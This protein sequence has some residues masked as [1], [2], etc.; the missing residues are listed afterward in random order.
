MNKS[1]NL[2]IILVFTVFSNFCFA[3]SIY[4]SEFDQKFSCTNDNNQNIDLIL[5]QQGQK[6]LIYLASTKNKTFFK[7]KTQH[8]DNIAEA[9]V[10][11]SNNSSFLELA[12]TDHIAFNTT[13]TSTIR[14]YY[15]NDTKTL[16]FDFNNISYPT[17]LENTTPSY[18]FNEGDCKQAPSSN[19][20]NNIST[21]ITL[22]KIFDTLKVYYVDKAEQQKCFDEIK[23]LENR[24]QYFYGCTMRNN[25]D[26]ENLT[27]D[28]KHE[29][30][31][32][33]TNEAYPSFIGRSIN[34]VKSPRSC[35]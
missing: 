8:N 4:L 28:T 13:D 11:S 35:N 5:Y 24:K 7:F 26:D 1:T 23:Q 31:L 18:Q 9:M 27:S 16:Q 19:S 34:E 21:H 15:F 3:Q 14:L 32:D 25:F 2:C 10:S 17:F 33:K 29:I 30:C 22:D 12:G 6:T 20:A